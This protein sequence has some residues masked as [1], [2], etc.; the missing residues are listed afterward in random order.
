MKMFEQND[1]INQIPLC[2]LNEL[3]CPPESQHQYKMKSDT[4]AATA[5]GDSDRYVQ[6]KVFMY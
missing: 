1:E 2:N 6:W 4:I 3:F 5:M